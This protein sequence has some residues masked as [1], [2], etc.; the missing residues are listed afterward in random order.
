MSRKHCLPLR[1]RNKTSPFCP[2]SILG[3]ELLFFPFFWLC[4]VSIAACR[5]S[6]VGSEGYSLVVVRGLLIK[7]ASLVAEEGQSPLGL[8]AFS[9]CGTQAYLPCGIWNLPRPGMEPCNDRYILNHWTT[10]EVQNLFLRRLHILYG[11]LSLTRVDW[12]KHNRDLAHKAKIYIAS[13]FTENIC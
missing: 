6:Q 9:S 7:V 3:A 12:S 4:W 11:G 13:P 8:T 2:F 1:E 10:R 5:L